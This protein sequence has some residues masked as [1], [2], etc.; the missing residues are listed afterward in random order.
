MTMAVKATLAILLLAAAASAQTIRL[1]DGA[2]KVDG[3]KPDVPVQAGDLPSIFAVYAGGP[4]MPPVMGSYAMEDDSL[5]FHPRFSLASGVRYRAVLRIPGGPAIEKTFDGPQVN[6]TPTTHVERVFPTTDVLPSNQ[7]KFYVYFSAPMSI[8]EA[9]R[10][11]QLLDANGKPLGASFLEIGTELWDPTYQ[12]LTVFLD[13]GRIK[14][15]VLPNEQLGPPITEGKRYI[16]AIDHDFLDARGIPLQEGFIKSFRGGPAD[17]TR[18]D[19]KRWRL[20]TPHARTVDPLSVDFP[21]PLDYALLQHALTIRGMFGTVSIDRGETR[22][23]FRPDKPWKAGTYE[24]TVDLRLEDLAGNRIDRAFDVD[25]LE[26]S[27]EPVV[28]TKTISTPFQI[29]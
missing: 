7:L 27:S 29:Q 16:L 28:G 26:K 4:D 1:E 18:I 9:S 22:W 21:E 23:Q 24:L 20:I 6:Q 2:F 15:G 10:H 13:P 3:W 14:Q 25:V 12:R 8:G 17:R 19:P 5:T 11:I